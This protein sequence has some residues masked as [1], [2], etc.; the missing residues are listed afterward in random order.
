M[1]PLQVESPINSI[2][3][4]INRWLHEEDCALYL[5]V[6]GATFALTLI[7][8][9][10][11]AVFWRPYCFTPETS[12]RLCTVNTRQHPVACR[13]THINCITPKEGRQPPGQKQQQKM[14]PQI[15][16]TK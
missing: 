13:Q 7:L 16:L 14:Q 12:R 4:I 5:L 11:L 2:Y 10:V 6:T 9:N 1:I 15:N 3:T 8:S